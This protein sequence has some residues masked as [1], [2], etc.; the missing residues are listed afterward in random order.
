MSTYGQLLA[1]WTRLHG[2]KTGQNALARKL[3]EITG[4]LAPR[5]GGGVAGARRR[6]RPRGH[7]SPALP[8]RPVQPALQL[9]HA[10]GGAG[11]AAE[12]VVADRRRGDPAGADRRA[13]T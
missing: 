9:L 10:A 2:A 3:G 11:V 13:A 7:G 8:D 4:R 6:V 5:V 1:D 12:P